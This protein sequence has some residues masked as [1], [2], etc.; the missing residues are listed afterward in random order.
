MTR[1]FT[2]QA[3]FLG[4][5]LAALVL[6]LP[7]FTPAWAQAAKGKHTP[8]ADRLHVIL[9]VAGYSDD[10]GG[11]CLNDCKAVKAA[12][13]ASIDKSKLTIH[14]LTGKNPRTGK[15]H[16]PQDVLDT[17]KSL[18]IAGN[19]NVLVYHSGHGEISD[20]KQPEA[21][22]VL[23]LDTG[24]IGRM[25]IQRPLEIKQPRAILFLTDCCSD[26]QGFRAAAG[27][28]QPQDAKGPNTQTVRN[29]ML[30]PAGL[31]SITA[32]EDGKSAVAEY[33]GPNP[34]KAGSAFTVALLRLWYDHG[35]TY[36]SWKQL[37]PVLKA[38]T[39][40]ASSNQHF[41]RAFHVVESGTAFPPPRYQA[42]W[43]DLRQFM[44]RK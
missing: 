26:F 18:K 44:S 19:D 9:L 36:T 13:E 23:G 29:L 40:K 1:F 8:E 21:S 41:A 5:A 11:P 33:V 12:L 30:K 42:S 37:F 27:G 43:D 39:G 17:V 4:S 3:R 24:E 2:S 22:H 31:V 25:Q 28:R 6:S 20:P 14:D 7:A 34:G 10:I 32:A 15:L 35:T 16:T 38:E